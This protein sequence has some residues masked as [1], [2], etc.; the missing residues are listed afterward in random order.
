MP[1]HALKVWVHEL[2]MVVFMLKDPRKKEVVGLVYRIN[3][4]GNQFSLTNAKKGFK[5]KGLK[6][7]TTQDVHDCWD[8][9]FEVLKIEKD[10]LAKKS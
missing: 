3:K 2:A 7:K 1:I 10:K 9:F 4:I 6:D 5:F 8:E